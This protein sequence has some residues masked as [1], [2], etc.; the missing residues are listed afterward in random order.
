MEASQ[1]A[2]DLSNLSLVMSQQANDS[3]VTR[4]FNHAFQFLQTKALKVSADDDVIDNNMKRMLRDLIDEQRSQ[5]QRAW[6]INKT[7]GR[8]CDEEEVVQM[9]AANMESA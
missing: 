5:V 2:G 4:E 9:G 1:C 3:Y 8:G 6:L 7:M